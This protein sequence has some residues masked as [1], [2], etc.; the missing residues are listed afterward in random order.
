MRLLLRGWGRNKGTHTHGNAE[1]SKIPVEDD[2]GLRVDWGY[3]IYKTQNVTICWGADF[4]RTG[5]Y[6]VNIVLDEQDVATLFK[7]TFGKRISRQKLFELGFAPR[8]EPTEEELERAIS[9]MSLASFFKIVG[10]G[11]QGD[12]V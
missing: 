4:S 2:F 3:K 8:I 9:E 10:S 1:L 7:I 12:P 11:L 5:K 6:M